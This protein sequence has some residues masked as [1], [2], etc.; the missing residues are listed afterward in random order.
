M[1]DIGER[2]D[3]FKR[4]GVGGTKKTLDH[5]QAGDLQ[6]QIQDFRLGTADKVPA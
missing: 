5:R 3:E 1:R 2:T 4:S 6:A